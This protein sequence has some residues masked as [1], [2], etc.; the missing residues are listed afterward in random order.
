LKALSTC[1]WIIVPEIATSLLQRGD[2]E[3]ERRTKRAETAARSATTA[4]RSCSDLDA[5]DSLH[6]PRS[7][8]KIQDILIKDIMSKLLPRK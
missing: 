4:T 7:A 3:E 1:Q 8:H 2:V 5:I 6:N